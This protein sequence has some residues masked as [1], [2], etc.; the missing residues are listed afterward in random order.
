MKSEI[1]SKKYLFGKIKKLF[2]CYLEIMTH[3]CSCVYWVSVNVCGIQL[4]YYQPICYSLSLKYSLEL[5]YF[6]IRNQ[7]IETEVYILKSF[8]VK[9]SDIFS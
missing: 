8:R 5:R 7:D 6:S 9:Y 1:H 2:L 3:I 4:L